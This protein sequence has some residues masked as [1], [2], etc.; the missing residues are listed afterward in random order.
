MKV[1]LEKNVY[2]AGNLNTKM[3][4]DLKKNGIEIA[5]SNAKNYSLNHTKMMI[6]DDEVMISTGNYSYSSFKYNRE[7]F[8]FFKD[9]NYLQ[10]FEQIFHSDFAGIKKDF[11]Q[12]NLVL[13]PYSSRNKLE[14]LIKNAKKSIQI[15]AH[16]ISD[17]SILELLVQAHDS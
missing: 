12:S 2:L 13:S 17:M 4:E 16:N 5:Y 10:L 7:F 3:F 8:L 1:L 6:I 11:S 15:Y 9:Q 14:Y